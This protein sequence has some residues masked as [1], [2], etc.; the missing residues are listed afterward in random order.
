[1]KHIITKLLIKLKKIFLIIKNV[2]LNFIYFLKIKKLNDGNYFIDKK[3]PYE[4]QFAS[5]ELTT[6]ILNKKI[7]AEKDPN[8]KNFGFD[9]KKEYSYWS[10]RICGISCIKMIFDYYNPNNNNSIANLT[11]ENLKLNGYDFKKDR[12][13]FFKQLFEQI[14]IHKLNGFIGSYFGIYLILNLVLNKKF[15]IAS[16]N[17][18]T[19][20]FDKNFTNKKPGGHLVLIIGF[21]IQ[22][23]KITGFFL[24]NPSGKS[25]K[26]RRQAFV[27]IKIFNKAYSNKG[28]A[29]WK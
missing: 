1:M 12:G 6:D 28:I 22:N 4:S 14:K 16:V 27:P 13:W 10:W 17:P 21:K 3:I 2:Y 9:S 29:V 24:N 5:P 26:T 7:S 20:R 11:K 23:K 15:F 18:S 19:I 8:W 25:E